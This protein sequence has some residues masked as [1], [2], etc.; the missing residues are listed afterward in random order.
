MPRHFDR[1]VFLIGCGPQSANE[2]TADAAGFKAY[3][4]WRMQ[5]IGLP[6]PPAFVL[7]TGFCRAYFSAHRK[8]PPG[9]RALLAAHI[10]ELEAASGLGFGSD[11]KPLLVSVR[12]GAPVSMP[13]MMETI[14]DV[15]MN[16]ATVRGMLRLTGNPRLAW[17]SYRRLIQSFAE[18]AHGCPASAF[19]RALGA[20][21][22]ESGLGAA[23]ELDFQSLQAVTRDY[24]RIFEELTGKRFPQDPLEQLETAVIGVWASWAADKAAAYRRLNGLAEDLGTAVTVQRMVYGNAGGTSGAGVAFTRDPATGEHSLY[25]DFIFNAQGEDVVSG[26]RSAPDS[27]RLAEVLPQ[28]HHEILKVAR[29]LEQEFRDMQEFEF[30]IQDGELFVLQT[31][32]GKSTSWAA[33]RIAVEQADEGLIG[34]KEALERA[35]TLDLD[36]IGRTRIARA[37]GTRLLCKAVPAGIGVALGEIV[38]DPARVA[39]VAAAGRPVIL[40]RENTATED[41]IG[42]AAA[43]GI[44]TA[45]GGRTSHAAVVARQLNKVCLVGCNALTVD[46]ANRRCSIAGEWFC[47]GDPLCLDGLSGEV[48]VGAAQIETELPVEYLAR[49][50][51]WREIADTA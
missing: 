37:S 10:R 9:L 25:L 16:D 42:I 7:G 29:L 41:I 21:V 30:T 19:D 18:V 8:A 12:S 38:L 40:V 51:Q 31:R 48:L 26:R 1:Q 43:A 46:L 33:L 11:R 39:E 13:G 4:L 22:A 50:A 24:L 2:A 17:D 44:L 5:R 47:E 6:V 23:H 27:Q 3:N 32:S 45:A 28:S 36:R 34:I 14:L 15:G 20:R 49:L 35:A